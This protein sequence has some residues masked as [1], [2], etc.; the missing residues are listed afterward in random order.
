MRTLLKLPSQW[1]LPSPRKSKAE[2]RTQTWKRKIRLTSTGRWSTQSLNHWRKVLRLWNAAWVFNKI[3]LLEWRGEKESDSRD[4]RVLKEVWAEE[5]R[6]W[7]FKNEAQEFGGRNDAKLNLGESW[8]A[9]TTGHGGVKC[10]KRGG[11]P[12]QSD[13][14]RSC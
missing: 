10:L 1:H 7:G 2:R 3:N 14:K 8:G 9:G 11:N 13:Q 6:V 12:A 5:W 4:W